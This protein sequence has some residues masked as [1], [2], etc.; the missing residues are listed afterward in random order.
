MSNAGELAE[1]IRIAAS[2]PG[3]W[4]RLRDGDPAIYGMDEHVAS[5][6]S[7]LREISIRGAAAGS[8]AAPR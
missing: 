7:H 6:A 5:P 8:K 2:T 4:E 1:T 3:L